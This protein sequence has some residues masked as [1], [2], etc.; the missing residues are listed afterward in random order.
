MSLRVRLFKRKA[1]RAFNS[2]SIERAGQRGDWEYWTQ[3]DPPR[4]DRDALSVP[5]KKTPILYFL[6]PIIMSPFLFF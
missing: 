1:S 6:H 2:Y 4:V 3:N 5:S